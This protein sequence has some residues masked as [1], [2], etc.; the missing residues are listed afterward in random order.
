MAWPLGGVFRAELLD[1]VGSAI[2]DVLVSVHAA[3]PAWD[4]RLHLHGNP[5]LV[6]RCAELLRAGDFCDAGDAPLD[7]WTVPD[8]LAAE[9]YAL[10]P[11]M[12]TLRGARWPLEQVERLRAFCDTLSS[13]VSLEEMRRAAREMLARQR[14]VEWLTRPLRVVLAGPPNAGKSTL[15]N[16]LADRAV[17]VVSATPGT[18]RDWV[19]VRSEVAGFPVAWIDTAGL[20]ATSDDLE[21]TSVAR[22]RRLLAEADAVVLVLDGSAPVPATEIPSLLGDREPACVALNKGDLGAVTAVQAALPAAWQPR[23]V[24]VSATERTGLD[25]LSGALLENLGRTDAV[26][27]LPAVFT[28]RQV[29]LLEEVTTSAD[30]RMCRRALTELRGCVAG[31]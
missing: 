18:T 13:G 20:R 8:L 16:A 9:A 27:D 11:Q 23:A 5:W 10:L 7:L 24:T 25:K 1:E 31:G 30:L 15:V 28:R 21:Q 14:V 4:I 17:S 19:E 6:R 29:T 2:D 22:T 3:P 26:V 12:S